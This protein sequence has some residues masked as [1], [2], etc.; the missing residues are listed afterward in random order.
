MLQKDRLLLHRSSEAGSKRLLLLLTILW[1][2]PKL[3][4]LG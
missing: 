1:F 4:A 2:K 3:V